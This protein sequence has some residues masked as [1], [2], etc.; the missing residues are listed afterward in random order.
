MLLLLVSL[1]GTNTLRTALALASTTGLVVCPGTTTCEAVASTSETAG[2]D[3][4]PFTSGTPGSV[5]ASETPGFEGTSCPT[6]T[7]CEA[8]GENSSNQ[9]LVFATTQ[10]PATTTTTTTVPPTTTTTTVP[11][12]SSGR[13][14]GLIQAGDSKTKCIY[15]G[16][17]GPS[18]LAQDLQYTGVA[19][20]C[21][22][23]FTD[24]DPAW[25]N[26]VSPWITGT[27][28]PYVA[29]VAAD[30]TGHQLI[31]TQNLIPDSEESD[32]NWTAECAAGD[33]NTYATQFATNMVA[34]GFGYSV[35]RLGHEMN[36]TWYNDDLGTTV[37]EWQQWAQCFAQEVTAMRAVPGANF[38]FDWNVN[39]N[40]RNIPLA[41]FYP[42]NA[43]VDIIGIDAYDNTGESIPA[44]GQPGRFQAL[45]SQS[46]G[47]D[48]VE[49]FA[50]ANGKPLSIPEWGTVSTQGDDPAYVTGMANFIASND[51][52]Y[53][54]WFNDGDQSIY[55]LDPTQDPL[56]LSAYAAAFG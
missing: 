14:S 1:V 2:Q 51:V 56:S 55:Q 48:A 37:A 45:A 35:I 23:T 47:L 5:Q 16:S 9:G 54:S 53:Q 20:N 50:A 13:P 19:Y 15:P 3:L 41:D 36:G 33:F 11:P 18:Q 49:A 4:A 34:A 7:N 30:P 38:L 52:A 32:P 43:Y 29:W 26:W 17:D 40:Y 24:A 39:A 25:A 6:T 46:E 28:E 42:G 8:V 31:D 27:A 44:V 10:P 22:E 12:V 21:I